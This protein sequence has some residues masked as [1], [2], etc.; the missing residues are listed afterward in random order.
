MI[1]TLESLF[2]NEIHDI[3]F[4]EEE[5]VLDLKERFAEF[6]PVFLS[7]NFD[8]IEKTTNLLLNICH[9]FNQQNNNEIEKILDN[10]FDDVVEE[11]GFEIIRYSSV[12]E[13]TDVSFKWLANCGYTWGKNNQPENIGQHNYYI[14]RKIKVFQATEN[15]QQ[16][17][18][19]INKILGIT[20]PTQKGIYKREK[21]GEW[22]K[23]K[24]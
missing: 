24:E 12:E 7:D 5:A 2:D 22:K 6:L 3:Y 20:F 21:S 17:I 14:T 4:S 11:F 16:K 18:E 8:Y 23:I 13:I 1:Y 15:R 10:Y 9:F 19:K